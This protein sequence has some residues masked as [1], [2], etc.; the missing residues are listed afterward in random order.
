MYRFA[1]PLCS[2]LAACADGGVTLYNPLTGAPVTTVDPQGY[3]ERRAQVEV[4]VKSR[5]EAVLAD[6]EAGGGPALS[7]AMDA[8]AVPLAERADRTV[9]MQTN[10]ST[11]RRNP[12]ALISS[13]L[14]YGA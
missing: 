2:L 10:L 8:A 9:Q 11:Y 1:L 4:A 3:A 5:F 7:V 13:L 6:I 12:D 14:L